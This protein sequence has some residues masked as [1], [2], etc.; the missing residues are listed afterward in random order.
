MTLLSLLCRPDRNEPAWRRFCDRYGPLIGGWC[1]RW[2]LQDS[3][4]E[5]LTQQ[6]LGR[7]V[8]RIYAYDRTRG[9]F[10]AWLQHVVDNAVRDF[11]RRLKRRP[12]DRGT[13]DSDI[14]ELL[15]AVPSPETIESLVEDLDS[16]LQRDVDAILARVENQFQPDTMRAFRLRVLE[17]RPLAEIATELGKTYVAVCMAIHRVTKKLR[18][19]GAQLNK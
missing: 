19:E 11:L 3:D 7:L 14:L 17:G 9:R 16:N 8:T 12:G 4:V 2:R 1:R 10:R 6:I 5:D 15:H 13:G 18:E